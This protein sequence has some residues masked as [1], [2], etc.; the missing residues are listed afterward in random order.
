M[1]VKYSQVQEDFEKLNAKIAK[2][3]F[4]VENSVTFD[5]IT[6]LIAGKSYHDIIRGGVVVNV[7]ELK[8]LFKK[9][10]A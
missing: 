2:L 1:L 10:A 3:E 5:D 6:T 9:Q 7:D 4:S 8:E